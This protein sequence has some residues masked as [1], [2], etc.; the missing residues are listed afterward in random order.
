[1]AVAV[2]VVVGQ[3]ATHLLIIVHLLAG[4]HSRGPGATQIYGPS[5]TLYFG[6]TVGGVFGVPGGFR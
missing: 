1:M 4:A 2:V 5:P 3:S 6:A